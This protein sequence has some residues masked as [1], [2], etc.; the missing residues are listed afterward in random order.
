MTLSLRTDRSLIRGESSSTRYLLASVSA[1]EAPPRADRLPVNVALILDRSGSMQGE[2]KFEL[3]R[4]AAERAIEMLSPEDRFTLVVYDQHV[5]VL[6][7]S[8]LATPDAKRCAIDALNNINPR[9]STDLCSGW[10]RGCEGIAEFLEANM[11]ARAL[12]LTDGLANHGETNRETLARHARELR[13]RGIATS[14]FGV[15]DDFDERLL[16]D[17]AREGG[18]NFYFI[19]SAAQIADVLTSELGEALETVVRR[20]VLRLSLPSGVVAEP[21]N[22]LPHTHSRDNDELRVELGDL[23]SA[24]EVR[25]VIRV[26][27]PQGEF[28]QMVGIRAHLSGEEG[29]VG[30]REELSW[31]YANHAEN[32][33]QQRDRVVDR[34]VAKIYATIARSDATEF[35]RGG[36]FARVRH[37]LE[38]TISRIR[39][40]AGDDPEVGRIWMELQDDMPRWLERMNARGLKAALYASELSLKDRAF[41]GKARKRPPR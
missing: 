38:R 11:V 28:G 34:E 14:T 36:D 16:R 3:V 41:D 18:G 10:L 13:Q 37:V 26:K 15:G 35:N 23:V 1:P 19:E 4:K 24:Q 39:Q 22:P 27:F 17:M 32:D 2:R 30:E 40:Y 25:V 6:L 12:L 29:V 9:G 5:D 33:R 21:V 20:A 8:S 31:R 7:A